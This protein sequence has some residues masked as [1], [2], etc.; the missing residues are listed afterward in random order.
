MD[1]L[2]GLILGLGIPLF[3]LA[4][5]LTAYRQTYI[6]QYTAWQRWI[7]EDPD[8]VDYGQTYARPRKQF[9]FHMYLRHT[10]SDG[11]LCVAFLWPLYMIAYPIRKFCQPTVKIPSVPKIDEL[12]KL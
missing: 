11:P 7:N 8:K 9:K 4:V 10:D 6:R 5:G 12:E 3:Y 2:I 1:T